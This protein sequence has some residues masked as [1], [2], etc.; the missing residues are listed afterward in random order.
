MAA[1]FGAFNPGMVQTGA[2][3]IAQVGSFITASRQAAVDRH[4]Q[5]YNNK[6][7]RLTAAQNNNSITTNE[8]MRKSRKRGQLFQIAKSELATKASAEVAAAAAGATGNSVKM[9]QFDIGRNAALARGAIERDDQYQ[10]VNTDNQRLQVAMQ[11]QMNLDLRSIPNPTG[12]T[13][14]LGISQAFLDYE[15][16]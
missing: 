8:L 16:E 13:Q 2:S 9:S 14:L 1:A 3:V 5:A 11:T 7:T 4:W 12:A 6:M 15:P 10:D